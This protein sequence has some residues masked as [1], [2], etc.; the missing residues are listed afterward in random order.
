MSSNSSSSHAMWA[1]MRGRTAV[2]VAALRRFFS[3]TSMVITWRLRATRE[4]RTC[5]SASRKGRTGGLTTSA[6]WARTA[7]SRASVLAHFPVA[8]A[9]IHR[10]TAC[11]RPA[12]E[13]KGRSSESG[14]MV[15]KQKT[16]PRKGAPNRCY[17]AI[18]LTASKSPSMITAWWP[19]PGYSFPP[20][21]PCTSVFPNWYSSAWT[22]VM[23][24][25]GP[26]PATR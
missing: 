26:T 24:R 18:T 1:S 10:R 4:L 9:L 13:T 3:E 7:V 16:S 11:R 5:V 12:E 21:W 20:P 22:W 6:K 8:L 19:M 25:A 17:H 14:I 2:V 23:R 15:L